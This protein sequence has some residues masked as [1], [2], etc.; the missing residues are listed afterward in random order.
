MIIVP[1]A[2]FIYL[3][4]QAIVVSC[5]GGAAIVPEFRERLPEAMLALVRE[6][7]FREFISILTRASND[8][9]L[10]R[11]LAE[12][13]WDMTN[14]FHFSFGE[15]TMTPLDFSAIMG[16]R[17]GGD[18][19]P[20]DVVIGRDAGAQRLLLGHTLRIEKED[21]QYSQLLG[22]WTRDPVGR[23]KEE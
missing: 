18:P 8:C 9:Q 3:L 21:V 20:F 6:V 1:I 2:E 7:G 14:S 23:V 13:W 17:V 4:E 15:M 12:R 19:I 16:L 11:A 5:Y 10:V 22:L